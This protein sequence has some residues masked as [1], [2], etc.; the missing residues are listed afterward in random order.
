VGAADAA[1][2]PT[3][4]QRLAADRGGD[5]GPGDALAAPQPPAS[6]KPLMLRTSTATTEQ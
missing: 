5:E 6:K 2:E 1:E 4:A 3:G